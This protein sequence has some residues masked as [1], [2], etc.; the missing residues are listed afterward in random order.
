MARLEARGLSKTFGEFTALDDLN[1]VVE[2]GQIYGLLGANGAGKSTT[3]KLFL[4]FIEPSQGQA[5]VDGMDVAA[6]PL[7]ARAR[8]AYLPEN[9]MLYGLLT[10]DENLEYFTQLGGNEKLD[11]S[12]K[13]A[14]FDR[15]GLSADCRDRRVD[16]YSKGMRQKLGLAIALARK[17]SAFLLDEPNSGL[18]PAASN[19]LSQLLQSLRDDGAAI[20]MATHDLYR[21]R[22]DASRVGIMR[23][24]KLVGEVTAAELGDRDLEA[25]YLEH[26]AA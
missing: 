10:G 8:L 19:D 25:M 23:H 2:P 24:G 20:L 5:L 14:L 3:L 12:Q 18:D 13:A 15:V 9:V 11:S 4:G 17:A 7:E 1:L 26:M 6:N 16:S 21:A 22:T